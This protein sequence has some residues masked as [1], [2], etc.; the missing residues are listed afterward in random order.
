MAAVNDNRSYDWTSRD[1]AERPEYP[2]IQQWVAPVSRVID[3]GCGNGMLLRRLREHQQAH[4][5]G[6]EI[7][8]SGVT[9]CQDAGLDVRQGSVDV[10]LTDIGDDTFDVAVCNVTLHMVMHPEVTLAEM[11][12]IAPLQIVSFPNFAFY[13]NRL[14]MTFRGRMPRPMLFGYSWYDTGHIHQ[15]SIRDFRETIAG[16]GLTVRDARYLGPWAWLS[17]LR[18]N[19]FAKEGIFLLERR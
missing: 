11:R 16:M 7:S 13:R 15:L 18:P 17:R 2:I 14:E 1:K 12:R 9:V 6:V 4:T 19:L 10:P 5:F 8:P 3:L